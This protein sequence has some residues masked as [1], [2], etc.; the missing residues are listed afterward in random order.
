MATETTFRIIL[1]LLFVAMYLPRRY[2][3]DLSRRTAQESLNVDLDS[4]RDTLLQTL[5]LTVS[6]VSIVV[7]LI[8][9]SWLSWSRLALPDWLRW[10]GAGLALIGTIVMI[11]THLS[12]G[13]NFFAGMKL[14]T[15]HELVIDGPFRW[16][17]HPM[18]T[19]FILLG[20]GYL[21]LS[22]SWL[23]GISWLLGVVVVLMSRMPKE[24]SM[25][26]ERFGQGY[27]TYT[28]RTGRFFPRLGR[29]DHSG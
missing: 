3:Q 11:W 14:R 1:G 26:R 4:R 7:F 27:I 23:I 5:P 10:I 8:N 18:Y 16:I 17:R 25:M 20:I 21:L 24:E 6:T 12:L 2:F 15:G 29:K 9:P 22:A 13:K 28:A 19:A